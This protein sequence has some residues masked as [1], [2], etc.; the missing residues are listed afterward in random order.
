MRMKQLVVVP[1]RL[2]WKW[3]DVVG[4]DLA[5]RL[6]MS[7]LTRLTNQSPA[8]P[9]EMQVHI[10]CILSVAKSKHQFQRKAGKTYKLRHVWQ[11]NNGPWG[12]SRNMQSTER[13]PQGRGTNSIWTEYK[14]LERQSPFKL[15]W[16]QQM[17]G[18]SV[19]SKELN[20]IFVTSVVKDSGSKYFAFLCLW[21]FFF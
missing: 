21:H 12:L 6:A 10:P 4:L 7:V 13:K 18:V 16:R 9:L 1:I 3:N 20:V 11:G 5:I 2:T 17:W 15:T 14:Q 8:I 19:D